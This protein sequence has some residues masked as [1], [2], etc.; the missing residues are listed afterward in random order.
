VLGNALPNPRGLLLS[1]LLALDVATWLHAAV[2]GL[3]LL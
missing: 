3:H 1:V 2:H